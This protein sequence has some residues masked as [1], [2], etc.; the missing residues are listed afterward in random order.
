LDR[1]IQR[2]AI[3]RGAAT[4][5]AKTALLDGELVVETAGITDFS[6]LQADLAA[7]RSDRFVYYAFDLLFCDGGDLTGVPLIARKDA[8]ARLLSQANGA[9]VVRFGEHLSEGGEI[10][11]RHA[12]RLG[13]EGIVSKRKDSHY[14]PGRGPAWVKAKCADR[15][16]FV[17]AGFVPSTAARRSVGSLVLGQYVGKQLIHA[18]RAGSGI[19][20]LA[21]EKLWSP[22][23]RKRIAHHPFS[24]PISVEASRQ[25]RWVEPRLP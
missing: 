2:R 23:E 16:E 3:P 14:R 12:C 8:L 13:F 25:V 19:S 18:G 17:I 10:L 15:Q 9:S 6:A 20:Q 11:L 21:S 24:T 22:L 5:P 1:K 7:G 4:I